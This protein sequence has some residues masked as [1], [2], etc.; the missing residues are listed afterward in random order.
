MSSVHI[1]HAK[2]MKS[3]YRRKTN[4]R[5]ARR[6]CPAWTKIDG[7]ACYFRNENQSKYMTFEANKNM[8]RRKTRRNDKI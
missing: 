3:N 2:Q 5:Q 4:H 6:Q 1:G 8:E 7:N